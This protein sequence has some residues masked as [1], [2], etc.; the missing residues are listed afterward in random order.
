MLMNKNVEKI[1][2]PNEEFTT[3]YCP[4]CKEPFAKGILISIKMVCPHCNKFFVMAGTSE[5]DN[6]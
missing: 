1:T 5:E 6:K 2:V 4:L 3:Y